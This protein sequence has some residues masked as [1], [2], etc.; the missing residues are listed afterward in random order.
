MALEG[1]REAHLVD[2]PA[3]GIPRAGV[4]AASGVDEV[5]DR[6]R[7]MAGNYQRLDGGPTGEWSVSHG[8]SASLQ[9]RFAAGRKLDF[10]PGVRSIGVFLL[11]GRSRTLPFPPVTDPQAPPIR[12]ERHIPNSIA[13]MRRRLI[14]ALARRLSRCPCCSRPFKRTRRQI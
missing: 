5:P 4:G 3:C 13:T 10:A 9:R 11:A 1:R 12:P 7:M 14:A 6:G 8:P 2:P